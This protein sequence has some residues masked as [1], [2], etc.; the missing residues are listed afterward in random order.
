VL[1]SDSTPRRSTEP[2]GSA[3]STEPVHTT[4][5]SRPPETS[6][7][8]TA[9][10][11]TAAPP[12]ESS[13]VAT[14]APTASSDPPTT[15]DPGIVEEAVASW[16]AVCADVVDGLAA[17]PGDASAAMG[18]L[19]KVIS[20]LSNGSGSIPE[21][22]APGDPSA[23]VRA[24]MAAA[25]TS[26]TDAALAIAGG[27]ET[28]AQRSLDESIAGIEQILADIRAFGADC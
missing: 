20:D 3:S 24:G 6:A 9:P 13:T 26:L 18:E 15:L 27:D 11:I 12:S 17:L 5:E 4:V 28:A 10:T 2:T 21:T 23:S 7:S 14:V 25:A 19:A 16:S 8:D 1:R 22:G